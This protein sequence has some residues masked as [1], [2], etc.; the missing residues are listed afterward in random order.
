MNAVVLIAA[1]GLG[2]LLRLRELV[3]AQG[4]TAFTAEDGPDALRQLIRRAP[5]L[6]LI[7]VDTVIGLELCRDM[8]T[9]R[10]HRP[11]LVVAARETRQAAFDTGCDAFV[12]RQ[13]DSRP[14]E[15]AVRRFLSARRPPAMG[16]IE[17]AE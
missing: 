1:S 3:E 10:R 8:K 2:R 16:P 15:Q 6:V 14:L 17:L 13:H 11:V 12:N 4:A 5:D 7:Y 9:L